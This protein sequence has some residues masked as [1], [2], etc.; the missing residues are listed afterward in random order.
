[1]HQVN[2]GK[3]LC[4]VHSPHR[5]ISLS[6]T[7]T[8]SLASGDTSDVH[9]PSVFVAQHQYQALLQ[10]SRSFREPMQI[11]MVKDDMLTW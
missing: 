5:V 2:R 6:L 11:R 7:L 1:M 3:R 10:L 8:R 9:I 4:C